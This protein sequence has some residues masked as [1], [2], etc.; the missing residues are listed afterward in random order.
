MTDEKAIVELA[1]WLQTAPGR[2]LLQWESERLDAAVADIFGF[3]A[4]QL[5]MPELSGLRANRMPHRWLG[6]EQHEADE[7][8]ASPA[9]ALLC[10]FDA[11]PFESSS[12]DLVLLPHTLEFAPDPHH[13][14]REVERVLRPEGRLVITGLNP[15]SAWGLRQNLGHLVGRLPLRDRP[16]YLPSVGEFIGYWRLRDWLRLLSFE[17]EAADFGLYAPPLRSE[18]WLRRWDWIEPIGRHWWPVLGAVYFIVAVKRVH[19]M[20]LVGLKR[21]GKARVKARAAV[22]LNR[23]GAAML[24]SPTP[25]RHNNNEASKE[26]CA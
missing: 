4:L 9:V 5:G 11:L 15:A 18:K 22:A 26:P 19:G 7:A 2:H 10:D 24:P 3:H 23:H 14:L 6:L 16:P 25:P 17:V 1:T 21:A 12:L 8:Q 20:R 13:T